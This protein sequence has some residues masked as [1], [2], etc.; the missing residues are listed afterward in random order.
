VADLSEMRQSIEATRAL[1]REQETA[2]LEAE[3]SELE[4]E[5]NGLM[6]RC[7]TAKAEF[8]RLVQETDEMSGEVRKRDNDVRQAS[9]ML[10]QHR[11]NKVAR[12]AS[13]REIKEHTTAL[14][15]GNRVLEEAEAKAGEIWPRYDQQKM[16]RSQAHTEF[17]KLVDEEGMLSARLGHKRRELQS[18]KPQAA[19]DTSQFEN[20]IF[21]YGSGGFTARPDDPRRQYVGN[22]TRGMTSVAQT[23]RRYERQADPLR[24]I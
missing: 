24:P 1:L 21:E 16:K 2:L 23:M 14:I 3:V 19:I 18:L 10:E 11:G 5:H 9:W 7:R 8:D 6:T 17:T 13:E 20:V 4:A 15:E 22:A 12:F